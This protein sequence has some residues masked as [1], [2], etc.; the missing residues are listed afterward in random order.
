MSAGQPPARDGAAHGSGRA[1]DAPYPWRWRSEAR[2]A[3]I[4]TAHREDRTAL[5]AHR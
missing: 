3:E 1:L 5:T 4:V 2:R